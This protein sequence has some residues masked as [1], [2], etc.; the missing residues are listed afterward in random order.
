[1]VFG[2]FW[3]QLAASAISR[4]C[5]VEIQHHPAVR[6]QP[7]ETRAVWNTSF[8]HT[9]IQGSSEHDPCRAQELYESEDG[10]LRQPS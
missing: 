8:M 10:Q 3:A 5:P 7:R 6:A 2:R 9:A 4:E 1:M